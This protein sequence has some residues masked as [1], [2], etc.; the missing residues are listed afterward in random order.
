MKIVN[1]ITVTDSDCY[2]YEISIEELKKSNINKTTVTD[3]DC[4]E[5]ETEIS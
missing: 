1:N 2:E 4:Y 3:A 5:Y